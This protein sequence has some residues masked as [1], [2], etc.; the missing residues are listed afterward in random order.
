VDHPDLE[1]LLR[2]TGGKFLLENQLDY[3]FEQ[4]QRADCD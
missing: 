1:Q 3:S 2:D 4:T